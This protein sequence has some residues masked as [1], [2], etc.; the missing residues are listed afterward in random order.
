MESVGFVKGLSSLCLFYNQARDLRAVI[1]GDDFTLLGSED[2]LNWF[3]A[4]IETAYGI[5]FK[6]RLGPDKEITKWLDC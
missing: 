6:A 4:Q 1:Y 2:A 3:E 5:D